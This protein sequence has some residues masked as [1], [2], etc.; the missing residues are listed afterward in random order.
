MLIK[1]PIWVIADNDA[2]PFPFNPA[3]PTGVKGYLY[4]ADAY[5]SPMASTFNS[6][7]V[8]LAGI[9]HK[10]R[11][12]NKNLRIRPSIVVKGG[13]VSG[14]VTP[15]SYTAKAYCYIK[16]PTLTT[17]APSNTTTETGSIDNAFFTIVSKNTLGFSDQQIKLVSVSDPTKV[18]LYDCGLGFDDTQTL[19][20]YPDYWDA[21]PII[22]GEQYELWIRA[23][24][25]VS[26]LINTYYYT[27][28]QTIVVDFNW[29]TTLGEMTYTYTNNVTPSPVTE[30][31]FTT[32]DI[33]A[34][35]FSANTVSSPEG[36]L[37]YIEWISDLYDIETT[38]K[39][40]RP[41]E[42]K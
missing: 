1:R 28:N 5:I 23:S 22:Q 40:Y 33:P 31:K 27:T 4:Q 38:Y 30:T 15:D 20:W 6:G 17:I 16:K 39:D 24:T 26:T 37:G 29:G 2:A 3:S 34:W 36:T 10:I 19:N 18:F 9:A 13:T 35:V 42:L 32:E 14:T 11:V 41:W 12:V 7:V 21:T 25:G 8:G